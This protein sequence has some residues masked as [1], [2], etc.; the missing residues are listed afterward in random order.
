M[1][2]KKSKEAQKYL[3]PLENSLRYK[4][5]RFW[6]LFG[7]SYY[8]LENFEKAKFYFNKVLEWKGNP[9]PMD[10]ESELSTR[11]LLSKIYKKMGDNKKAIEIL[12]IAENV[13]FLSQRSNVDIS[14]AT[15]KDLTTKRLFKK[16]NKRVEMQYNRE[17]ERY[18]LFSKI[19]LLSKQIRKMVEQNKF[20]LI[21]ENTKEAIDDVLNAKIHPKQLFS[22][23]GFMEIAVVLVQLWRQEKYKN[24]RKKSLLK[25]CKMAAWYLGT[26]NS[27]DNFL[28]VDIAFLIF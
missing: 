11:V 13:Q 12:K 5:P 16:L 21:V 27:D 4:T 10:H 8:L 26:F 24:E 19:Q 1:H 17:S 28:I 18:Y 6:Y 23:D 9:G 14:T 7:F 2:H 15:H 20:D 3:K 22:A 25:L